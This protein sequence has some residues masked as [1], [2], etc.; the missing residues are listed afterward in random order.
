M[1][2]GAVVLYLLRIFFKASFAFLPRSPPSSAILSRK[3]IAGRAAGPI[4]PRA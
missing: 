3:E 4:S 2:E 1:A